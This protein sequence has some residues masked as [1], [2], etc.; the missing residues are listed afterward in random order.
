MVRTV[1]SVG[2]YAPFNPAQSLQKVKKTVMRN[3]NNN[4]RN[5]NPLANAIRA[6]AAPTF[7]EKGVLSLIEDDTSPIM[8]LG[9][10]NEFKVYMDSRITRDKLAEY[11]A[12]QRRLALTTANRSEMAHHLKKLAAPSDFEVNRKVAADILDQIDISNWPDEQW[13]VTGPDGRVQVQSR[14][15]T[16]VIG[17]LMQVLHSKVAAAISLYGALVAT[18]Q[19]HWEQ[20][21]DYAGYARWANRL[22]DML[23]D[24]GIVEEEHFTTVIEQRTERGD[25]V[26]EDTKVRAMCKHI[27]DYIEDISQEMADDAVQA[28]TPLPLK[29]MSRAATNS[30]GIA[31]GW[32]RK[33]M[34]GHDEFFLPQPHT[35]KAVN[36]Q[37]ATPFAFHEWHLERAR[38]DADFVDKETLK[39][40]NTGT[41]EEKK[42][43]QDAY[44][45]EEAMLRRLVDNYG[46]LRGRE[47][48][49]TLKLDTR[50]RMYPLAG[51]LTT[52]GDERL[53]AMLQF[54]DSLPLGGRDGW[55]AILLAVADCFG[56][57]GSASQMWKWTKARK[58]KVL[59]FTSRDQIDQIEQVFGKDD[60]PKLNKWGAIEA[61][62][63]CARIWRELDAGKTYKQVRS[64]L[65]IHQDASTSVIQIIA[66]WLGDRELMERVNVCESGL[67][68]EPSDFYTYIE[69]GA[70]PV[71]GVFIYQ[72]IRD[73]KRDVA[74]T[75]VMR[76]IYGAS[77]GAII[78]ALRE[79][80]LEK[81]P[82]AV[83]CA[84]ELLSAYKVSLEAR[85]PGLM[86][87]LKSIKQTTMFL[88][89]ENPLRRIEWE[90]SNG[91]VAHFE[92]ASDQHLR[93]VVN[94]AI[95]LKNG[96]KEADIQALVRA[97]GPNLVHSADADLARQVTVM[98]DC[99]IV[100]VH[101][102][103]G[104]H[105]CNYFKLR[106]SKD[107]GT[108]IIAQAF[109]K[110]MSYDWQAAYNAQCSKP[111]HGMQLRVSDFFD[112]AQLDASKMRNLFS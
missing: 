42:A 34:D 27:R 92:K 111:E 37:E 99:P 75:V 78:R 44:E 24:V 48:Y 59:Q 13:A 80:L 57:K 88:A 58:A 65:V 89:T 8:K 22:F 53:R 63:E 30:D 32:E 16:L 31:P 19:H 94:K 23:V 56:I 54:A 20:D 3:S 36:I 106:G 39:W 28:A 26:S 86:K 77:D 6:G 74:K 107:A 96:K 60:C 100:W 67:K 47:I 72:D 70:R 43:K 35:I 90:T 66:T 49:F 17:A 97:A 108:G 103:V 2:S 101:D 46:H 68:D 29:P 25:V 12:E 76:L 62:I 9:P 40:L 33:L 79:K 73:F 5:R 1:L 61:L 38:R 52:Q 45:K 93:V 51:E 98:A 21:P 71:M 104:V 50:T 15:E 85:A 82:A 105:A 87:F 55:R 84:P 10:Y 110:V 102:S 14:N 7:S 41:T 4:T 83:D 81:N 91:E 112:V 18:H 95:F 69:E 64:S 109:Q 11:K